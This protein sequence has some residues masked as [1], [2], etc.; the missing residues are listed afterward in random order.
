[1]KKLITAASLAILLAGQAQASEWSFLKSA[2]PEDVGAC[3][4]HMYTATNAVA[5]DTRRELLDQVVSAWRVW[6]IQQDD[7]MNALAYM[8][9]AKA[10]VLDEA[11]W[12]LIVSDSDRASLESYQR[13]QMRVLGMALV[14]T[15][16]VAAVRSQSIWAS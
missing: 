7:H 4:G 1:M 16:C 5:T 3:M 8:F 15:K 11:V 6:G 10:N 14:S 2:S 13:I 9:N 12:L